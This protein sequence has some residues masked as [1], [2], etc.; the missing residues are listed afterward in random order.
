MASE[1]QKDTFV[2]VPIHGDHEK[3]SKFV[4]EKLNQF[5][6]YQLV[7]YQNKNVL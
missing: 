1:D 3:Y 7:M 4:F 2:L 5:V 6:K